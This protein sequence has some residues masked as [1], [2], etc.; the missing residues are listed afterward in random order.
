VA[1]I[2][3]LT[4]VIETSLTAEAEETATFTVEYDGCWSGAYGA[5]GSTTS[6]DGC[7]GGT[8]TATGIVFAINAQKD[9]DSGDELCV[10]IS[11]A[12][13]SDSACT[14]AEYGVASVAI[15]VFEEEGSDMASMMMMCCGSFLVITIVLWLWRNNQ[16]KKQLAAAVSQG[17]AS[18]M[19]SQQTNMPPPQAAATPQPEENKFAKIKEAKELF[20][21]GAIT[22][23]E[24]NEM[25][26]KYL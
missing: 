24:F 22:E 4:A 15:D 17:V 9:D 13:K 18:A 2:F 10:S 11:A 20:D 8:Y 25:K 12:G 1:V 16:K 7:G 6:I 21:S 14:T 23:D 26:K 19:A 5:E 3:C